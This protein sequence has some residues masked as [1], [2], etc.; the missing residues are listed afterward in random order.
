[1]LLGRRTWPTD[2]PGPRHPAGST[3]DADFSV[4]VCSAPTFEGLNLLTSD[5]GAGN[6]AGNRLLV[7]RWNQPHSD[8]DR[9]RLPASWVTDTGIDLQTTAPATIDNASGTESGF[10]NVTRGAIRHSL[11]GI[12]WY[13]LEAPPTWSVLID[14]TPGPAEATILDGSDG[15]VAVGAH[16]TWEWGLLVEP[17]TEILGSRLKPQK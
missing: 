1:M 17:T 2:R 3:A 4:G 5:R 14:G 9:S 6:S 10:F 16:G 7:D 15:L 12:T 13:L 8:T 11:D